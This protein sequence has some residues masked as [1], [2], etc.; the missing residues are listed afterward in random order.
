MKRN[1]T[2]Y[3]LFACLLLVCL[4]ILPAGSVRAEGEEEAASAEQGQRGERPPSDVPESGPSDEPAAPEEEKPAKRP[5]SPPYVPETEQEEPTPKPD[6][7]WTQ[8]DSGVW[9]YGSSEAFRSNWGYPGNIPGEG[10]PLLDTQGTQ[11]S[12]WRIIDGK[13]SFL[14]AEDAQTSDAGKTPDGGSATFA[15]MNGGH[16]RYETG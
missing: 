6:P 10:L 12:G 15:S 16:S 8:T 11:L 9:L 14:N 2:V 13:L 3:R 4:L 5:Y 1:S 7:S